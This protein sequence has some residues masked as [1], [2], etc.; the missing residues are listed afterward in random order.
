[1][2]LFEILIPY[3]L[4]CALA[5]PLCF[6]AEGGAHPL[7]TLG[8]GTMLGAILLFALFLLYAIADLALDQASYLRKKWQG[9]K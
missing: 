6:F 4:C 2:T 7:T 8:H 9:R 1:M 3:C 5:I